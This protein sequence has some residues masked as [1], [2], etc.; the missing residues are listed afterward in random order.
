[1]GIYLKGQ[2]LTC[3]RGIRPI[4]ANL[5]FS[6][7]AGEALILHGPN[8]SGKSSLIKIIAGLLSPERGGLYSEDYEVT[9]D[10]DWISR[11][12]CYLAHKNGL[13]SE[14]TVAENMAFWARI[15]QTPGSE[16]QDITEA[17]KIFGIA[18]CLDLPV[19]C[20][21]SGQAR[22]VALSRLICHPGMIWL[23][24]EPTVGLDHEG[25]ERL[26]AI[27]NDHLAKGGS[28]VT[29]THLELGIEEAYCKK[30]YLPD[31]ANIDPADQAFSLAEEDLL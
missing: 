21:S 8:G 12:I 25:V 14:M 20:L 27:M 1:M 22:R 26:S 9:A 7:T 23:L 15:Q 17:A 6:L 24:D 3:I 28:I 10:A 5:E 2:D 19:A 29:A 30:L 18:H 16:I 11:N 13:K 4:F 31:F